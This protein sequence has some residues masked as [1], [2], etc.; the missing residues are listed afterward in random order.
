M[1]ELVLKKGDI[2]VAT[3]RNPNVLA[4]LV[5]KHSSEKLLVLK[6]DV[7]KPQEIIDAFAEAER[8]F[9]HIDVVLNNAGQGV[10]G[11]IESVPEDIARKIFDVNFWGATNVSKEA[12]RFFRDVNKPA[13][14]R[15]LQVS[16][17]SGIEGQPALG[18]YVASKFGELVSVYHRPRTDPYPWQHWK[19]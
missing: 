9:G 18:I 5:A 1:T 6:L 16:S 7:T 13:G 14:G 17:L 10:L 11:E 3:L 12:V 15:L 2:A 8:K 19:G 4:D